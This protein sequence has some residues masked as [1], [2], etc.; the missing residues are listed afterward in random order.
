MQTQ[1]MPL[2]SKHEELKIGPAM[3]AG[4]GDCRITAL[5]RQH[6][7]FKCDCTS[8]STGGDSTH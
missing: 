8:P 7:C 1:N 5:F 6:R 2:Q 3:R 4:F